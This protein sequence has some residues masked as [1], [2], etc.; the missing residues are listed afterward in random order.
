[1]ARLFVRRDKD[2]HDLSDLYPCAL[3]GDSH[4][5]VWEVEAPVRTSGGVAVAEI[6][7]LEYP[8]DPAL[9]TRVRDIPPE[10][11]EVERVRLSRAWHEQGLPF[12]ARLEDDL[13]RRGK[14]G[15]Y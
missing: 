2:R 8:V 15:R 11:A 14:R 9:P 3:C 4:P 5:R 6:S 1:M 13:T 10:A 7:G 12:G